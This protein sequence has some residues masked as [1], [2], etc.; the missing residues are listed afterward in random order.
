MPRARIEPSGCGE[1]HGNVKVRLAF[2]L[3][4]DDARYD[5]RH[6]L[7]P[8]IPKRG[9]LGEVDAI[10]SPIDQADYDAWIESLPKKWVLAPFHNHF[11]YL[12]PD[13]TEDVIVAK[14]DF[15]L[16]NFYAAWLQELDKIPSGMRK[17]WAVETRER[18]TRFDRTDP[19]LYAIRKP[20]CFQKAQLIKALALEVK[21]KEGGQLFPATEIDIGPGAVNRGTAG[22]D[23]YT[24]INKG[25][26]ANDDGTIDEVEIWANTNLSNCEVATFFVVSG[27]NLSTRDSEAIGNVTSGSKQ[28]FSA[29]DMDVI[30]GD[31]LG[32]YH[33]GTIEMDDSGEAGI[34]YDSYD[35]IPCTNYAFEVAAGYAV[36]LY[37]TGETAVVAGIGAYSQ[38]LNLWGINKY[39][40]RIG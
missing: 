8:V 38:I 14:A 29:L 11:L 35:H 5:E 7:V 15:H 17:G 16:P 19:E 18:P 32:T 39:G 28:T 9:Y 31:Y 24:S 12:P 6:Y 30:T 23:D 40:A 36:S 3:T 1:F 34:W 4:P 21:G 10:G 27:D 26:P 25:N 22:G 33:D 2:Y 20:Q 13:V 37:G